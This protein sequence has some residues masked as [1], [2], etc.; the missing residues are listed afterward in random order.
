M[1]CTQKNTTDSLWIAALVCICFCKNVQADSHE[2]WY[3]QHQVSLGAD[4]FQKHCA[5][6]H[7]ENAESV[8]HWKQPDDKNNYPPPPLNGSAHSWHHDLK[9][10]R[11][12]IRQGGARLGGV[13]PP[14]EA[15]LSEREID[16]VIAYFQ[17]LWPQDI[18][19]KWSGRF[20]VDPLTAADQPDLTL[21]KQR[22]GNV[23]IQDPNPTPMN[24]MYEFK[25]KDKMLYLSRDGRF[26]F[27]GEMIDLKQGI[28]LSKQNKD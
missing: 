11:R 17:S 9:V 15:V 16:A 10:L 7:G 3:S 1:N 27:I 13:M 4:L 28:N 26:A 18:Y 23:Q 25:F 8:P 22:L 20:R 6:C 14:F 24:G 12:T 5:G 19:E 2:T 21:L